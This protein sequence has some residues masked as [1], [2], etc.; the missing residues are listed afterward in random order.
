MMFLKNC[1]STFLT[2]FHRY[3]VGCFGPSDFLTTPPT[4]EIPLKSHTNP[5]QRLTCFGGFLA[6]TDNAA[7][8]SS[9]PYYGCQ[10]EA[11]VQAEFSE[12]RAD[13]SAECALPPGGVTAFYSCPVGCV[14]ESLL[15]EEKCPS[16]SAQS[17]AGVFAGSE[18]AQQCTATATL[19]LLHEHA[20]CRALV[21]ACAA[22]GACLAQMEEYYATAAA[23]TNA[24]A[25]AV[26]A[27]RVAQLGA[28][29]ATAATTAALIAAADKCVEATYTDSANS[30]ATPVCADW[31]SCEH[32]QTRCGAA[33][34]R[35]RTT[36]LKNCS[37][38]FLADSHTLYIHAGA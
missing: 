17:S 7:A 2:D 25:A 11:G 37:C 8:A 10:S 9:G 15:F 20:S 18:L 29:P 24:D 27:C 3:T 14:S 12:A 28:W 34:V 5:T 36:F 1:W 16:A 4:C 19:V 13:W 22:D 38:T 6:G 26:V 32:W 23:V 31:A 21:E 35:Q 30:G 33:S